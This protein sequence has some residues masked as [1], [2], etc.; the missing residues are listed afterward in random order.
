MVTL[1]TRLFKSSCLCCKNTKIH[2]HHHRGLH[3][4]SGAFGPVALLQIVG[5]L[6]NPETHHPVT[7]QRLSNF[8]VVGLG[9][10][11]ETR[12]VHLDEQKLVLVYLEQR[13]HLPNLVFYMG[14]VYWTALVGELGV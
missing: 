11:N 5:Y 4:V 1:R 7:H 10:G 2:L 12:E 9:C 6:V 14:E 3:H 13:V 8:A